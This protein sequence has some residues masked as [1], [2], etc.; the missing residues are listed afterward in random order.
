[1]K[2]LFASLAIAFA[3]L[4]PAAAIFTACQS[5]SAQR[6]AFNTVYSVGKTVDAGY[7]SYLDL[8][9]AGKVP[10]NGVPK[11][12]REYD[13]FQSAFR[14]ASLLVVLNTNAPAPAELITQAAAFAVEIEAAKK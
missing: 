13:A 11:I 3:V 4:L 12:A 9:V 2:K 14:A 10:T 7:R 8:V 1:M 5:P 6:T